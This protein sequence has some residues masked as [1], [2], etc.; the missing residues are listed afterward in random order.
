MKNFMFYTTDGY[1]QDEL[2]NGTK[3]CQIFGF[4]KGQNVREAYDNSQKIC[5]WRDCLAHSR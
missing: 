4:S 2:L 3:N 5:A 1:T